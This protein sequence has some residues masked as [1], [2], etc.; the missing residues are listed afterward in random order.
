M[1]PT[2]SA[3]VEVDAENGRKKDF[4]FPEVKS[5]D[6]MSNLLRTFGLEQLANFG[7]A[8]GGLTDINQED[9]N[10]H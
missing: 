7:G 8:F 9:Q 6:Q 1:A 3:V 5:L 2:E 4:Q 10:S